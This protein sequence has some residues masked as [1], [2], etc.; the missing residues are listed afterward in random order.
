MTNIPA[1]ATNIQAACVTP[2][3]P[4]PQPFPAPPGGPGKGP[5]P[6]ETALKAPAEQAET[7]DSAA[8]TADPAAA[9]CLVM[10]GPQW[11]LPPN[12]ATRP[13]E[14]APSG[15]P[16]PYGGKGLP[17]FRPTLPVERPVTDAA[18]PG[19]AAPAG[20]LA[21]AAEVATESGTAETLAKLAQGAGSDKTTLPGFEP[22]PVPAPEIPTEGGRERIPQEFVAPLRRAAEMPTPPVV[23][24]VTPPDAGKLP[25]HDVIDFAMP[26]TTPELSTTVAA[27]A[28]RATG[29]TTS[30]HASGSAVERAAALL[31]SVLT[32]GG[33]ST[34]APAASLA[35]STEPAGATDLVARAPAATDSSPLAAT[36]AAAPA[37]NAMQSAQAAAPALPTTHLH[38]PE[39]VGSDEWNEA[40]AQRLSQLTESPHS[41]ASI[42]LNPP[43][44]GPMQI[45]VHVDGDR[46]VVSL[47]VH[48]DATRDAL[49]QAMPR[50]RA[51]LED[52]GFASI[53]VS[54]SRNP[55]RQNPGRNEP[56]L[57]SSYV[58]DDWLAPASAGAVA[59]AGSRLLD[60]Y[61]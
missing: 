32:K 18:I 54:V 4:K 9:G 23:P 22:P 35:A 41:R 31:E 50:L 7:P 10:P 57:E 59:A 58:A 48:H 28:A 19:A 30:A 39:T 20:A 33:T 13:L 42:R 55:H 24:I 34:A 37:A 52:N 5:S 14:L 47:A 46:A 2:R 15:D 8:G 44:L 1:V 49:E 60:A 56:Y 21:A 27:V 51:Q 17:P 25:R 36:A 12:P 26:R 53:D 61:A 16:L 6:A 43:Q 11:R 40:V 45:E 38:L 29:A 3:N